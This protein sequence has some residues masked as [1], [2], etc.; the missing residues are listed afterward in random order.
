MDTLY[1][2]LALC[3][4][5]VGMLA[6]LWAAATLSFGAIHL[7]PGDPVMQLLARSGASAQVMAER[8]AALGWDRPLVV[9]Y[10]DFMWNLAQGDLG[11]SW[12]SDRP[13]IATIAEAVSPTLELALASMVIAILVGLTLGTL[14]ALQHGKWP[15][16]VGMLI[17]TL[18]ISTPTAWS[19]LLA[20]LVFSVA[21]KWLPPTGNDG[22]GHL[23]LPSLVLGLASAGGIARLMRSNLQAVLAENYITAARA[24]GLPRALVLVRHAWP[25]AL[26]GVLAMIAVQAGFLMGGA[27]V[28]E[29]LFAR[30]GLGRLMVEA[31]LAQDLPVVQGLVL[32]SALVYSLINLAADIAH[33]QLDPRVRE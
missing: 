6:V 4:R 17:A 15:D 26:P 20:I 24:K 16:R 19:G 12:I 28:T 9:Q 2:L 23:I 29:T 13:V 1:F 21:L 30:R 22:P 14:A 11:R 7:L 32:L 31:V 5:L 33:R 25:V 8:R 10:A 3:R 18:S 27:A